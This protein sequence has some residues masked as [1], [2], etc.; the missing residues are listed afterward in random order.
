MEKLQKELVKTIGDQKNYA[1]LTD[2]I[3]HLQ[4]MKKD[5]EVNAHRRAETMN[6]IKELQDFIAGQ[7]TDI[8]EIDESNVL[9][10]IQKITVYS[11]HSTVEFK[12]SLNVDIAE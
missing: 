2:D 11:D 7:K 3:L 8:R 9:K 1:A 6:G 12:S 4:Q 10:L 5:S